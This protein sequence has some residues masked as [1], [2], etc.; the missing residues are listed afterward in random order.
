MLAITAGRSVNFLREEDKKSILLSHGV[1]NLLFL[2]TMAFCQI[3]TKVFSEWHLFYGMSFVALTAINA[4][5]GCDVPNML[6]SAKFQFRNIF[7]TKGDWFYSPAWFRWFNWIILSY[8]YNITLMMECFYV[9]RNTSTLFD[10]WFFLTKFTFF[11]PNS[12]F[13]IIFIPVK[14]PFFDQ[15]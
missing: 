12:I 9:I 3:F 5:L 2:M 8:F 11:I 6:K 1:A 15:F 10:F 7:S 13:G 4:F 14:L